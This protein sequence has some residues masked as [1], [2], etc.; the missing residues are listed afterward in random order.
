[1]SDRINQPTGQIEE[2]RR[3]EKAENELSAQRLNSD[4]SKVLETPEGQRVLWDTMSQAG[5]F[6]DGFD[7]RPTVMGFKNGQRNIGLYVF[8]KVQRARPNAFVQMQRAAVAERAATKA[9][10]EKKLKTPKEKPN[11]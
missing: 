4:Y 3:A 9:A 6:Q 11:A 7:E 5:V 10:L 1:M 8:K 2:R